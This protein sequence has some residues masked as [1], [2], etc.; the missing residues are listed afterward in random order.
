MKVSK[1]S[2]YQ[3]HKKSSETLS[4]NPNDRTEN[5]NNKILRGGPL[6]EKSLTMPKETQR[7]DPL[8]FLT[9]I[10]SQNIKQNEGGPF[11]D[12][13]SKKTSH[14]AEK[15]ERGPFSL[16]RYC[17]LQEKKGKTFF[18]LFARSNGSI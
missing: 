15:S 12:F 11:G 14:N 18:I 16:A 9:S 1:N 2:K 17:T 6:R 4:K 13:F 5:Q 7:G 3:T 8:R 10:L